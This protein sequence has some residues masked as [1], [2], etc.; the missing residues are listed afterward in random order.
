MPTAVRVD[1]AARLAHADISG[2]LATAEMV[3]GVHDV[4]ALLAAHPGYAVVTDQRGVTEP[5]T[6][7]QIDAVVGALSSLSATFRGRHW[8]IV[9]TLPASYGMMRALG[10]YAE[11]IPIAVV[12][13]LD[14]AAARAWLAVPDGG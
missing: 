1:G 13:F 9:T 7:P 4:A 11:Q 3:A 10:V 14:P 8:A 6:R 2:A 12:V 5:A